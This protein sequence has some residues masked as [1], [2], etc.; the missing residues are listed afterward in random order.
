MRM[1]YCLLGVGGKMFLEYGG[2]AI[3]SS[4]HG[5]LWCR[6]DIRP[7]LVALVIC[8]FPGISVPTSRS[9]SILIDNCSNV[10]NVFLQNTV[11]ML[12]PVQ[13]PL[14][15]T[16]TF[17]LDNSS[18]NCDGFPLKS[19]LETICSEKCPFLTFQCGLL[20]WLP[21]THPVG[22]GG[23]RGLNSR[24]G[25]TWDTGHWS[26]Y[27]HSRSG[28]HHVLLRDTWGLHSGVEW[29]TYVGQAL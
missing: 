9:P 26:Q 10:F 25:Q 13:Y 5:T 12:M 19:Y 14:M 18:R 20:F 27:S 7:R 28:G 4:I 22:E 6:V 2:C 23:I 15:F 21:P 17:Y 1:N 29:A 11:M 8:L 16:Y 3:L 24:R